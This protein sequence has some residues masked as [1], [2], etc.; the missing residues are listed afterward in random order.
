MTTISGVCWTKLR[1]TA[2][3]KSPNKWGAMARS[4]F[5]ALAQP[6]NTG[7]E[8]QHPP[9]LLGKQRLEKMELL[10]VF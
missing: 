6:T 4:N 2:Q 9:P 3:R 7:S 5:F 10:A 1:C 8:L